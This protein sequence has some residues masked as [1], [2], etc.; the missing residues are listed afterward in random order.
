MEDKKLIHY[1]NTYGVLKK[2]KHDVLS[3][4]RVVETLLQ[5]FFLFYYAYLIYNN[6]DSTLYLIIY[7][8]LGGVSLIYFVF[9]VIGLISNNKFYKNQVKPVAKKIVTSIKYLIR[10]FTLVIAFIEMYRE[11]TSDFERIINI[12]S[13]VSLCVQIAISIV[14]HFITAY[15]D[16]FITSIKM[17]YEESKIKDYVDKGE[18]IANDGIKGSILGFINNKVGLT[19]DDTEV[20]EENTLS[21]QEVKSRKKVSDIADRYLE[22]DRIKQEEKKH[23][24][25]LHQREKLERETSRFKEGIKNIFKKNN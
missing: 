2:L 23:A 6:I 13:L 1:D 11:P 21:K 25:I 19:E 5:I 24:R 17:D 20:V 4:E 9:Y 3:I 16:L 18:K 14:S 22:E 12:V 8:I 10:I 7:S 15:V